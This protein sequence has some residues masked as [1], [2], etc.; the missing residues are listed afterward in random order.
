M[1]IRC[2]LRMPDGTL[3]HGELLGCAD[4]MVTVLV[5]GFGASDTFPAGRL[6]ELDWER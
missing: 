6:V 5:D 2:V 1:K 4:G 3:L